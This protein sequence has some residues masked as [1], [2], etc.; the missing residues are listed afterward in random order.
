MLTRYT[1]YVFPPLATFAARPVFLLCHNAFLR[2][3]AIAVVLFAIGFNTFRSFVQVGLM[4]TGIVEVADLFIKKVR[5]AL[6]F[7]LVL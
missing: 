4:L 6:L 7:L 1:L 5:K 3:I 2:N